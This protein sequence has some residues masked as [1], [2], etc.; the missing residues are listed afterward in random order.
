M[1]RFEKK[2]SKS[3]LWGVDFLMILVTLGTQDKS[4]E[5][6]LKAIDQQIEKGLIK[7]KVIV[8]AGY[9]K[10]KSSNMEIFDLVPQK[11]MDELIEKSRIVITH[12]GVGT[13]L[14]AIKKK[15]IVIAAARLKKYK[16]HV[17]DHQKQI[18]KEFTKRGY[19]LELRD[20]NQLDKILEKSK[21]FHPKKFE[22][23][24]QNMV[25]LIEDYIEKDNHIS[26]YNKFHLF[27]WCIIGIIIIRL[28]WL[29]IK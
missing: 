27:F 4:F 21:T 12:G 10:Y 3:N 15:K 7:E 19:I 29:F 14:S 13:I 17:N 18:I 20:F 24:T 23:N 16:E 22:S 11:E 28:V 26:W 5:R 25:N 2:L 9:T 6:L 1:G 8:Q